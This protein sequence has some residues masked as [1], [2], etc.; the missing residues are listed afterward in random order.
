MKSGQFV[1]LGNLQH[2][3]NRFGN[4]YAVQVKVAGDNVERV[5]NDLLM[6]LPGIEIQD[7][8]N[9]VLFCNVPFTAMGPRERSPTGRSFNLAYVFQTLNARKE[10]KVIESYSVTQTT[11]EQIFVQLAGEDEDEDTASEPVQINQ[12]GKN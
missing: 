7:Q 1:C 9:E 12:Q 3:R 2:L 5:K 11:L 10:Q 4:G 8:H 6:S